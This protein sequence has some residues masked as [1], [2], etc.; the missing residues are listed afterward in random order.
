M[1]PAMTPEAVVRRPRRRR[2]VRLSGFKLKGGVLRV[3]GSRGDPRAARAFSAARVTLDPNGGWLLKACGA[4]ARDLTGAAY[5]EDPA[6]AEDG[7]SGREVMAAS[8]APPGCRRPPTWW[9][10][11]GGNLAHA[12]SLQAVD[13]P[14]ADPPFW[15]MPVRCGWRRPA[16]TGASPGLAFQQP[17]RRVAGD[18][19]PCRRRRPGPR[20]RDR[21]AWIWQTASA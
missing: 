17:F 5:A 20:H 3:R 9:R 10:P 16:A 6:G 7:F 12:L 15:T 21:H 8:A 14:L 13:I 2:R 18:V 19:H 11:T 1:K 4:P